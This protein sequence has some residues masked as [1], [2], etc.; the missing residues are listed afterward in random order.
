MSVASKKEEMQR[1][2]SRERRTMSDSL[3]IKL[4]VS[5]EGIKPKAP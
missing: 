1:N 3:G 2:V 5:N 4:A